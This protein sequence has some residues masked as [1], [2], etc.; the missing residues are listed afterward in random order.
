MAVWIPTPEDEICRAFE[1]IQQLWDNSILHGYAYIAQVGYDEYEQ[2]VFCAYGNGTSNTWAYT[3]ELL[4]LDHMTARTATG[5]MMFDNAY[6]YDLIGNILSLTNDAV[7]TGPNPIGGKYA[8]GY[9]Y[10]LFNRLTTANSYWEYEEGIQ[11]D[12]TNEL[13]L[14]YGDMHRISYKCQEQLRDGNI[15][16]EHSYLKD[17]AYATGRNHIQQITNNGDPSG[18]YK[19]DKN[20]NMR[21]ITEQPWFAN[22]DTVFCVG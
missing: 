8:H 10:D 11:D 1:Q 7:A 17:Y 6:T 4:R 22:S 19:Y 21:N 9:T 3:P 2:K 20:G 14:G 5:N 15:V 13:T 12:Y 16:Q 18:T